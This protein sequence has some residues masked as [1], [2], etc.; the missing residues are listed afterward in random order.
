MR[1]AD[2]LRQ[3]LSPSSPDAPPSAPESPRPLIQE[4]RRELDRITRKY[5]VTS[6][7]SCP[8]LDLRNADDALANRAR[9]RAVRQ[10]VDEAGLL[11]GQIFPARHRFG[12]EALLPIGAEESLGL[13]VLLDIEQCSIHEH[14]V[15]P[16]ELLFVDIETT[17]LSRS[18]G[19]LAFLIGLGTMVGEDGAFQVEQLLIRDPGQERS[20]LELLE[21][22]LRVAR[23]LVSFNGRGFD[24]P[25]LRNRGIL[26]RI[27]LSLGH[28]HLDLLPISRRL[29]RPRLSNCR[30]GTIERELFGFERVGDIDGAEVPGLYTS[31]LRSGRWDDL[32]P[33]LEHNLLDVATLAVLLG[34]VSRHAADPLRWAED[35]EELEGWG[36][37]HLRRSRSEQGEAC[38]VRALELARSPSSRRRILTALARCRRRA[39]RLAEAGAAWERLRD[40]FPLENAGW[41]ELAKYHEHVTGDLRQALALTEGA[42]HSKV[43]VARRL[44]RLRSRLARAAVAS[45]RQPDQ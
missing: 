34:V 2:R 10:P 1:V 9:P 18:A 11:Y 17:G 39:G 41:I 45:P 32:S 24:L 38:L 19:T 42:P 33:V 22:R 40:E 12:R 14:P 8:R 28:P 16:G 15:A 44:Q 35:G 36:R 3:A 43:G 30:L 25:V 4:L 21:E 13:G 31:C 27:P 29:F 6:T 7:P 23:V 20:A 26:C 5:T 37:M